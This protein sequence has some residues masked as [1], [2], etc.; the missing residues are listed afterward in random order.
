MK[1]R[2]FI[3]IVFTFA[4]TLAAQFVNTSTGASPTYSA[5][6][7]SPTAGQ[8]LHPGQVVRVEWSSVL[9]KVR[10]FESCEAEVRLSLDGGNTFPIRISPWLTAKVHSFLWTVPNTPTNA[11]V[12]DIRFGCEPLYPE[13][14]SPQSQSMFVIAQG[15]DGD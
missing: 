7:I 6:L 4:L 14:F 11:A 9:P 1:T 3:I 8:V 5:R 2:V 13:S 15:A 12:V 10:Y